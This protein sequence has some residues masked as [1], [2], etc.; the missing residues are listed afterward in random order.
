MNQSKVTEG[1]QYEYRVTAQNAAGL[2]KPSEASHPF[3]A[4]PMREA[5]K[6]HLDGIRNRRIKVRAGEAINV[7][8]PISGAPTPTIDWQKEKRKIDDYRV[9]TD[10][11][12]NRTK[13]Y[14]SA[15]KRSDSGKYQVTAQNSHGKDTAELDVVVVDKPGPPTGPLSYTNVST[16]SI[17]LNW[18]APTDDGGSEISGYVIEKTEAGSQNWRPLP[19]YCPALSFTV[20]SGLEEAKRY[21][22]RVRAENNYGLSE[23]LEGLAVAAKS[24]FDPPDAPDQPKISAYTPTSCSLTWEPPVNSGGRPV[25]GYHVEKRD[26][27]GMWIRVNQYP[28]TNTN[29]TVPGLTE[30]NRYEFRVVAVND[31]GPGKASRPT[32]S[33]VAG[34]QKFAPDAPEP[35]KLDRVTKNSVTLSWKPPHN[36]GGLRVKGYTVQKKLKT[37]KDWEDV[38]SVLHN[39]TTYTVSQIISFISLFF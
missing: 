25:T 5:P 30:G 10:T 28:A 17:T 15:S 2:G 16:E 7:E 18:K 11:Q 21:V 26:R 13:L 22:F 3:T 31:A 12:N 39:D 4:K 6:L 9:V 36:D 24:P 29:Y 35:P 1:H 27:G 8:I 34:V 32:D 23:P 38:N 20:K 14:V 37:A 19:G 33:I